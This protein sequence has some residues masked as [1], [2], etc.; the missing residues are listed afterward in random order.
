MASEESIAASLDLMALCKSLKC[1]HFGSLSIP[2]S[3]MN[4]LNLNYCGL[5]FHGGNVSEDCNADSR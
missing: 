1:P 4:K 5:I 3:I 2:D